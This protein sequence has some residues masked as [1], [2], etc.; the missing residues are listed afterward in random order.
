MQATCTLHEDW[1]SEWH[2]FF[3]EC[4]NEI[5]THFSDLWI[6]ESYKVKVKVVTT[7]GQSAS[8]SWNKA[9]IW[10]LRP[11]LC[12][13]Q[14]VAGMFMWGVLSDERTGLSFTTAAG[15]RQRSHSRVRVPWESYIKCA[16]KFCLKRQLPWQSEHLGFIYDH[17]ITIYAVQFLYCREH[18]TTASRR[19]DIIV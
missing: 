9:P 2:F 16:V 10:G 8:L 17:F 4:S 15:P 14:T 18:M 5:D 19:L 13:C 12:Y 7:D 3:I 1:N 6:T 11:D